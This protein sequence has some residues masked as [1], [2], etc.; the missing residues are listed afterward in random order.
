MLSFRNFPWSEKFI[1]KSRGVEE[2]S[3]ISV[4]KILSL[5]AEN[6]HKWDTLVFFF[7]VLETVGYKRWWRETR[8]S[9]ELVLSYSTETC[10]R[11]TLLCRFS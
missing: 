1:D 7:R 10:H 6:F 8:F 9:N 3:R 4:E 2:V 11:G 5:S